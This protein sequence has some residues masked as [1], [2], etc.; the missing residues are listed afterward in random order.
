MGENTFRILSERYGNIQSLT[1]I[2]LSEKF[3]ELVGQI[4]ELSEDEFRLLFDKL[5]EIYWKPFR[6]Q[7]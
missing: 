5:F 4:T 3:A 1:A 6:K 7:N 2:Q